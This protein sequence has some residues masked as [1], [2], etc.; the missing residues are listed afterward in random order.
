MGFDWLLRCPL[1]P[2]MKIICYADDTL[3]TARGKTFEEVCRLAAVGTSLVV[4]R[5]RMLGMRVSISKTEALLFHG[6]RRGPPRGAHIAVQGTVIEVKPCMKYLGLTL[7]GRWKFETHFKQLE[8]RLV[9]AAAAL[10]RLL[11][12]IGGPESVCRRLYAGIVRSMALYGAP[13]WVHSLTPVNKVLLRRP[14]KIIAV[15]VIRG[16]RTVS[17]TAATLLAG[18]PPWEL[19]AEV[20]AEVY[21]YRALMNAQG[22]LAGADE[23][24][25]IRTLAQSV[26]VERWKEDLESPIAGSWTVLAVRPHIERWLKRKHGTLTFRLVQILTGHGCF[27]KYLHQTARR[28]LTPVCHQC[29]ATEDTAHHTLAECAAWSPQRHILSSTIGRAV[30][31]P[32]VVDA[33]IGSETCWTVMLSFCEAVMGL[34][35]AEE[36]AREEAA[37]APLIRR[38]RQ[39]RRRRRYAHLLPP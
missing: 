31:L 13:I 3:V 39:G 36:R 25:R 14:Q 38:R 7:D 22:V 35:E 5:I 11:P 17:W 1:L 12:N 8:V 6:P 28:E 30:S 10:G 26:L 29:G 9:K 16:Y 33:M 4:D 24:R 32:D 2:G 27:G 18:D 19:Q 34:K 15:R 23:V 21:Q 20:L 37:D